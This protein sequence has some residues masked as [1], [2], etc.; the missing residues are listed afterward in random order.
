MEQ[1]ELTEKIE[2]DE[3]VEQLEQ[4]GRPGQGQPDPDVTLESS[5]ARTEQESVQCLNA[6]ARL[7]SLVKSIR[8][9]AS[10]G[11]LKGLHKGLESSRE[12]LNK[13]GQT[14]DALAASWQMS[15]NDEERL[16]SS[17]NFRRELLN[18]AGRAG[19]GL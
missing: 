14:I 16:L 4:L 9:A 17:G 19:L 10:T 6:I 2:N 18:A 7:Q 15:E 12:V 3:K 8:H 13:A 1:L 11:D 5:L